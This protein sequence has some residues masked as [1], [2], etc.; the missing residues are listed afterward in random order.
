VSSIAQDFTN[1]G[2][3]TLERFY[4]RGPGTNIMATFEA[5]GFQDGVPVRMYEI[6]PTADEALMKLWN[7]LVE[8]LPMGFP[9]HRKENR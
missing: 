9:N 3:V 1:Y 7:A 8:E 5:Y 6:A 4:P 2:R